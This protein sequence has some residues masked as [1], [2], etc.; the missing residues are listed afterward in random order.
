MAYD[1]LQAGDRLTTRGSS[2]DSSP[3][4]DRRSQEVSSVQSEEGTNRSGAT[5][6]SPEFKV[7]YLGNLL[8]KAPF[9]PVLC[10]LSGI[11][12]SGGQ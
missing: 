3:A 2:M 9:D 8:H 6:S 5:P 1:P 10:E 11:Q 4:A 7:G 12:G